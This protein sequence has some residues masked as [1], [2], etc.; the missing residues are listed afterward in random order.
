M[1]FGMYL[2]LYF[3]LDFS[4][5]YVFFCTYFLKIENIPVWCGQ[6]RSIDRFTKLSEACEFWNS[7]HKK[8]IP[9]LSALDFS[10]SPVW[11]I[12]FDEMDFFPSLKYLIQ[13]SQF[14][15]PF[16]WVRVIKNII[17]KWTKMKFSRLHT[18]N[19]NCRKGVNS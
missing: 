10:N 13:K 9:Y 6:K 5:Y 19:V 3:L 15:N 11:N 12:K 18:G 17:S 7:K 14:R 16:R 4:Y 1:Q 8:L 2:Y